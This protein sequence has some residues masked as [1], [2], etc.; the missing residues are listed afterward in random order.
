MLVNFRLI[1][2]SLRIIIKACP[3]NHTNKNLIISCIMCI[4]TMHILFSLTNPLSS[5]IIYILSTNT[6]IYIYIYSLKLMP[7]M[8]SISK[9]IQIPRCVSF[10]TEKCQPRFDYWK[11]LNSFF[12][13]SLGY[14]TRN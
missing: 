7:C 5:L 2:V 3:L 4:K 12:L 10:V 9:R 11:A 6:Y 14:W 13:S 1:G 8:C